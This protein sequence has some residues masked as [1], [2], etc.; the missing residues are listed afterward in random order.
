M[1]CPACGTEI[2]QGHLYCDKCGMEIQMVP[3]FEPEIEKNITETLS[4]VAEEIAGTD[5]PPDKKAEKAALQKEQAFD[6]GVHKKRK[7]E[8]FLPEEPGKN[9]LFVT[10]V[11]FTTVAVLAAVM[12]VFM[13]HKYSA[14]YQLEQAKKCAAEQDYQKAAEY[15]DKA[16][17]LSKETADIVLLETGYLYQL[18]EKEQAL[19]LLLHL[20]DTEHMEYETE[21]K[22][23]A[24]IIAIYSEQLAYEEIASLL[25]ACSDQE[26]QHHFQQY[27]AL[28]PEFG[29]AAGTYEEVVPLKLSANTTGKI[30]YTLDGTEPDEGSELYTAPI[31]LESGEYQVSAVFINDYG[32]KSEVARGYYVINLVAPNPP[33][34]LLYS[35]TYHEVTRIEVA[36]E[37]E[38]TVYYT[39]DGSEPSDTSMKYT[40]PIMMPLGK[41]NFKFVT[42]SDEGVASEIISRSFDLTLDT[43]VTPQKAVQNV[44]E[45]LLSRRVLEDM[46][47]HSHEIEG[48]Y[49]FQ[50]DTIVEIPDLGYY[51]VL[52]EYI[53][54]ADGKKT[55]TERL[56]AVEIYTGTP[57]RL[58]YDEN[59]NMGLISLN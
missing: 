30:Y 23:Y 22:V 26:I 3:D 27:M 29:Y 13:Y 19:Q 34:V 57:N 51:Y 37:G 58:T 33:E 45:A 44:M 36:N 5:S 18:G 41:S 28:K 53:E 12:T 42:I 38:G 31:F 2:V 32:I 50:Y 20:L 47:G 56:Y 15:L 54:G 46:Q 6:G 4:N 1:K 24:G 25:T 35:G 55:K 21:E 9:W 17:E 14:S 16:R 40:E 11:A 52:D 8:G 48:K 7:E 59:G 10:I 39:T 43:D 49:V